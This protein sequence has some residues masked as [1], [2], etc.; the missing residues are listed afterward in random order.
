MVGGGMSGAWREQRLGQGSTAMAV[1][2]EVAH[3]G[4]WRGSPSIR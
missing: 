3:P 2:K 4:L 1:G